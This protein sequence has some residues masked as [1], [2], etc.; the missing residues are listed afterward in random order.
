MSLPRAIQ[1]VHAQELNS[2]SAE[3][4]SVIDDIRDRENIES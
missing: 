4:Y 3:D 1:Q 2:I